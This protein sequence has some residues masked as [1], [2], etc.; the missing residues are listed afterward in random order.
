MPTI[1]TGSVTRSSGDADGA[2]LGNVEP[3]DQ[4]H[5]G[6]FAASRRSDDGGEFAPFHGHG[7]A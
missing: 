4:L 1:E 2:R 7:Q 6:G 5:Q 3:G